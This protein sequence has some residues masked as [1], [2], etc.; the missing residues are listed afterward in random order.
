MKKFLLT[1]TLAAAFSCAYAD[2]YTDALTVT[3]GDKTVQNG[4]TVNVDQYYDEIYMLYPEE[5]PQGE[6]D[7]VI[8]PV[9]NNI[10]SQVQ[11][12]S[13]SLTR[14]APEITDDLPAMGSHL[15]FFQLCFKLS[16]GQENCLNIMNNVCSISDLDIPVAGNMILDVDQKAFT[17]LTPVT[18]RLD[19]ELLGE[20]DPFTVYFNFTHTQDITL[21]VAGLE[22]ENAAP[23]YFTLQ[24]TK[25]ANPVKGEIYI[26]R[27]GAKAFKQVF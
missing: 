7:A 21:G 17:D 5:G 12:V 9:V 26:V 8:H 2:A 4:E 6:F 1:A 19:V 14:T 10:S 18:L 24:G 15:G 27:K 11:T 16:S 3:I 23:E 22:A 20:S 25:V 13:V